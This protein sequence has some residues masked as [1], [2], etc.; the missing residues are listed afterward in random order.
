[1]VHVAWLGD[2]DDRVN[3]ESAADLLGSA[4]GQLFMGSVQGIAGLEGDDPGPAQRFKM[5]SQFGRRAPE[6]DEIIVG[7]STDHLEPAG[8]LMSGLPFEMGHGR[9]LLVERA[10]GELGLPLLVDRVNL[11]DVEKCQQ[12]AINIAQ[13]QRLPLLEPMPGGDGQG[14]WQGPDR[15]IRQPH[16][17]DDAVIVGL[18]HEP[19]ERRESAHAEQFQV[20][21]SAFVQGQ[22]SMILG[23]CLHLGGALGSDDKI[24]Q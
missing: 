21:K 5:T 17:G 6:L 2:A 12:V 16:L 18:A 7:R 23:G 22:A 11:F 14:D 19:I 4:L 15:A 20:T 24:D 1:M 10:I 8:G 13:G 3:Q 9:M